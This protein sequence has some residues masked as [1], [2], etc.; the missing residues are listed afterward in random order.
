MQTPP[1]LVRGTPQ[2]LPPSAPTAPQL[3]AK[4]F[5]DTFGVLVSAPRWLKPPHSKN[6]GYVPGLHYRSKTNNVHV[7]LR[8]IMPIHGGDLF[9]IVSR[10]HARVSYIL[11]C[12][13]MTMTIKFVER[14]HAD[15]EYR[16]GAL[17]R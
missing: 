6:P 1:P 5:D 15:T 11:Q 9:V 12:L 16:A 7:G 13:T 3:R 4:G 2:T 8:V 17:C 10:L 14:K